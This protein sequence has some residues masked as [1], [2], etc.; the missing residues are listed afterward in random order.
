[1]GQYRFR[2]LQLLDPR[3]EALLDGYEVLVEG[4][5]IKEVSDRPI[6]ASGATVIDV[7]GKTLM[8]GL[9][10]CHVH[11]CLSDVNLR[12]LEQMP[13]TLMTA[14]AA[15]RLQAMLDRGFTTVRDTGGADWGI[16]EALHLRSGHWCHGR[17]RRLP[18]PS[19]RALIVPVRQRTRLHAHD[20]R[21]RG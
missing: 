12:S 4:G 3:E 17:A 14:H 10:D 1:M 18:P 13:L 11:V 16:K 7:G 9:I 20:R 8:P 6:T 21:R 19:R 5:S 2:N 15:V